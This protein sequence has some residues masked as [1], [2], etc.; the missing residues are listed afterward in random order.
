MADRAAAVRVRQDAY[1][2]SDAR[3]L[4]HADLREANTLVE[5]DV[6]RAFQRVP[7]VATRDDYAADLWTR[8]ASA[9]QTA[10]LFDGVPL[11][12]GVHALGVLGGLDSDMLATASFQPG[13]ASASLQGAGAG[14][15]SVESRSPARD[16]R[17]GG[18]AISPVSVRA[19]VDGRV[20]DRFAWAAGARRSYI[21]AFSAFASGVVPR[22]G[23]PYAFDDATAR[24]DL[25]LTPHQRLEASG[26]WQDDR[27]FGDVEGVAYGN[28]GGWG[29]RIARV[30]LVSSLAGATMR[31]TFALSNFD[32]SLRADPLTAGHEPLQSATENHYGTLLW[33]ARLE[34]GGTGAL[35]GAAPWS[36]GARAT[37]ERHVYN[38]PGVDLA[39]LLS[40]EELSRRGISDLSQIIREIE[41]AHL[42]DSE[43]AARIALWGERRVA[44]SDRFTVDAGL[45]LESGDAI[46]GADL[47][48]A[49]RLRLRY[50]AVGS[51]LSLSAAYGRA[52]Q[53]LQSVATTDVLRAGL[54]ASEILVQADTAT[55]P[56]RSDLVSVG[57]ELWGGADWLL[58][59]TAWSRV[60]AG[61]LLPDPSPGTIDGPRPLVA[62]RGG[63]RG[64]EIS[65]RKL[66]GRTRAFAN[67]TLSVSRESTGRRAFYAS[68]DRRHVAN[69]GIVTRVHPE[70][71]LGATLRAQSGAPYT[72]LTLVQR[73]CTP[74]F[75]C[76]EPPPLF[77]GAPAAQRA[78]AFA[79][80][81]L[82]GEW[83]H[84]FRT[85]SLSVYGQLRN[86]LGRRNAVTYHASCICAAEGD[87]GQLGLHDTFDPGLPRMPVA[88]LR[89]RF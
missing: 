79:S 52:Y 2:T 23:V 58:G 87:A 26:F 27:V 43:R 46:R 19:T 69:I 61:I 8:G 83:T 84:A 35:A 36:L 5:D 25:A 21:D 16:G 13:V 15:V 1:L 86:A 67:Y 82:M 64:V 70:W 50:R 30:S 73:S 66:E 39:R 72:R 37:W 4:G 14:V 9:G 7:G 34:G 6:M 11:V 33:E 3:Q 55:A 29:A 53:Y 85:W 32:V 76:D 60:S 24:F 62:A 81:D 48:L 20:G 68:E 17:A 28:D 49:P 88:G 41:R 44:L 47:R 38:G 45:R 89:V 77:Y 10:V 74:S 78:P 12:G 40:P 63:A 80:F 59:A 31:N 71:L 51:P 42:L 75:A 54:R 56:L 18:V 22:G 65:V 57:A